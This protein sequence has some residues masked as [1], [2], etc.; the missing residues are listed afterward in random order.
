MYKI[1]VLNILYRKNMRV[2]N[3]CIYSC[4]QAKWEH[5]I[6]YQPSLSFLP[7]PMSISFLTWLILI[8]IYIL[9]L[10]THFHIFHFNKMTDW[11]NNQSCVY[12]LFI[13]RALKILLKGEPHHQNLCSRKV[14]IFNHFIATIININMGDCY[15]VNGNI[16]QYIAFP[17]MM[18]M[19]ICKSIVPT[20]NKETSKF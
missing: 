9:Y 3:P 10:H 12:A 11:S 7:S 13:F 20:H 1:V 16:V 2:R 8:Y 14:D 4:R 15:C 17:P 5:H 19:M 18:M 6:K